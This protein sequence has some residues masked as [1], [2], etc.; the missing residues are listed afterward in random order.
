MLSVNIMN[1]TLLFFPQFCFSCVKYVPEPEDTQLLKCALEL[2]L[3]FEQYPDALNIAI[4]LNDLDMV[5]DILKLC[6]G[7]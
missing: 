6:T 2:Y 4:Q 1:R 3:Q 7:E 5:K